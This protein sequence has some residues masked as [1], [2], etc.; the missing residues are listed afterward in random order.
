MVW[1]SAEVAGT[2]MVQSIPV[3]RPIVREIKTSLTAKR[4]SGD[5]ESGRGSWISRRISARASRRV[6]AA[7][8]GEK[9]DFCDIGN[10]S[11]QHEPAVANRASHT[12]WYHNSLVS[13]EGDSTTKVSRAP[14]V[15]ISWPLERGAGPVIYVSTDIRVTRTDA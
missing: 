12:A 3:V 8:D 6:E 2:I 5:L 14:R 4:L 11:L 15:A 7:G 13:L 9:L 1:Y 10:G